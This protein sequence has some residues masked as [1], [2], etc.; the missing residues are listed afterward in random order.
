MST[1]NLL[2]VFVENKPGQTAR[3]TKLLA[4]ARVNICWVT[5]ANSGSFGVMKFLV[6]QRDPAVRALKDKGLMVSLLEV[7]AV[8]VPDQPGSLQ[9][10]ADLLGRNHIN[11]D[12][13]SGFVANNR[14]ILLIE[15]HELAQARALLEKQGLRLLTQEEM[16]RL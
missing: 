3:I 16:L 15:V 11:L 9:A 2:A 10:V 5:I 12:N 13:C 8:E 4:D 1:V 14:A 6:D 7:L